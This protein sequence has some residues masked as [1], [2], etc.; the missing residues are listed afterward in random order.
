MSNKG[1]IVFDPFMG[2]GSSGVAAIAHGRKFIGADTSKEFVVIAKDRL[3]S[4]KNGNLSYRPHD[5]PV[6]DHKQSPLSKTDV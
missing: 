2:V 5:K 4:F 6:Y 3:N 1:D